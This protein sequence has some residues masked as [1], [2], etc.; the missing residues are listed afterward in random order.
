MS[1][2]NQLAL[3]IVIFPCFV[4]D[5]GFDISGG[6]GSQYVLGDNG[7]FITKIAPRGPAEDCG[8]LDVGDRILEVQK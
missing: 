8:F 2:C 7:I 6:C 4:A 5:Y 3:F 1:T